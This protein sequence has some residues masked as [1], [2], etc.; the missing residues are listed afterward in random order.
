M[1]KGG[2]CFYT[3]DGLLI[4]KGIREREVKVY[5]ENFHRNHRTFS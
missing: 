5:G 1:K 3:I 4:L 2:G